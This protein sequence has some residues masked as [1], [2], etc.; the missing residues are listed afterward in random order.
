MRSYPIKQLSY[1]AL[2]IFSIACLVTACSPK[3]IKPANR[4]SV[5]KDTDS[6]VLA[7]DSLPSFYSPAAVAID[8]AGNLYVADYGNNLIR[9]ITPTGLVSTL[10]GTG[11]AGYVNETGILASFNQPSGLAIDASGNIYV[12]DA[13]NNLIRMITPA[14]VTTTVAGGDTSTTNNG[15]INGIGINASFFDPA[16]VSLDGAGNIFVADAGNDLIRKIAP[17]AVVTSFAGTVTDSL[18]ANIFNNPTGV[19]LDSHGN[20]FVANYLDN[21]ILKVNSAGAVSV[22]AGTD[23]I[24]SANGP[25]SQATF[26]FPNSVA[27]DGSGNVYVSDGVNNLIRKITTDGTVSTLA[28]SGLAGA[29]D[30]TGTQASFNGPAGLTVD[31]TGNVYVADSNNNLIRKITPDG[32]VTTVAGNGQAGSKNGQTMARLNKKYVLASNKKRLN[33]FIR[34]LRRPK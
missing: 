11:T 3:S 33:M 13:G 9:K 6:T 12:A 26:Y 16:S 21:N 19:T 7:M 5:T 8:A 14:G 31:A 32:V 28:G 10:A 23:S 34:H 1:I 29:V 27:V 25:A 4:V 22:F 2:L 20:I 18:A 24:G 17:G 30:A 15:S